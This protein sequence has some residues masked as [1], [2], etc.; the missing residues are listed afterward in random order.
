MRISESDAIEVCKLIDVLRNLQ[1]GCEVAIVA[2]NAD[3]GGPECVVRVRNL[4]GSAYSQSGETII[5][6]L[7]GL[8]SFIPSAREALGGEVDE[9]SRTAAERI[10]NGNQN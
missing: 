1:E 5:E 7:R 10:G 4:D 2:D 8:A 6:C 3:F 9:Y